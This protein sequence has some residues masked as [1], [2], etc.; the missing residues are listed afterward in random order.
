MANA[1]KSG[2][3]SDVM[4]D[5]IGAFAA[6][7]A[8]LEAFL[9]GLDDRQWMHR[10]ACAGWTVADVVLH[11]AQ[12]E[13]AVVGTFEHGD[14]G[15]PFRPYLRDAAAELAGGAVDSLAEAA[16]TAERP[17]DPSAA[18]DRWS[19]AH[20]RSISLLRSADPSDRIGWIA[21]PLSVRTLTATRLSEHWIHGL[22]IREPLGSPAQDTDRLRFIA[23]LAWRTLP[24]AFGQVGED[25]PSVALRLVGPSGDEWT[26]GDLDE[27]DVVVS[28]SAGDWCRVAAR[29]LAPTDA[30]LAASGPGA[31][32]VLDLVRTYA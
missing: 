9:R 23:R 1:S 20:R 15:A 28:G 12:T 30:A 16:V 3:A 17:D 32:R 13:E 4:D 18:L 21:V 24:Y 14:S 31:D 26:F 10:S 29:R 19:T 11:L 8:E 6:E 7:T 2:D 22:D 5:V 27:A 25:A